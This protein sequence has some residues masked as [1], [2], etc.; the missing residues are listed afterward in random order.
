M[1]AVCRRY[2]GIHPSYARMA[3]LA[4]AVLQHVTSVFC[5]GTGPTLQAAAAAAAPWQKCEAVVWAVE[6][7]W[8]RMRG[9]T[10]AAVWQDQGLLNMSSLFCGSWCLGGIAA[11]ARAPVLSNDPI[12]PFH[13]PLPLCS[14][15]WA[16]SCPRCWRGGRS[17]GPHEHM[18]QSGGRARQPPRRRQLRRRCSTASTHASVR[19]P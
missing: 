6:V 2:V 17:Y 18:Q 4:Y 13:A 14:C 11:G 12:V 9:V 3:S 15:P 19:R 8:G 5:P 1:L 7:R 16:L 10:R